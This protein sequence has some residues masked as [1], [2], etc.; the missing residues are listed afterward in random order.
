MSKLI[1]THEVS[2]LT[3]VGSANLFSA[4]DE[5]AGSYVTELDKS[6]IWTALPAVEDGRAHAFPAGTSDSGGA[7]AELEVLRGDLARLLVD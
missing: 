4:N 3:A 6:S 5:E 1:L 7:T 2:G